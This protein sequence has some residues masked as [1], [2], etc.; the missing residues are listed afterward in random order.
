MYMYMYIHESC[1]G[2]WNYEYEINTNYTVA[3]R[4][5]YPSSQNSL[6]RD[7]FTLVHTHATHTFTFRNSYTRIIGRKNETVV[8]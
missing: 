1:K 3:H 5:R 4:H 7:I 6:M 8:F 2:E